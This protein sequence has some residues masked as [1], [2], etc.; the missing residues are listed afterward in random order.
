MFKNCLHNIYFPGMITQM[1]S[2]M[3]L[4]FYCVC[5]NFSSHFSY[6]MQWTISNVLLQKIW[7]YLIQVQ[8]CM[9]TNTHAMKMGNLHC[10]CKP[11]HEKIMQ[12][13]LVLAEAEINIKENYVNIELLFLLIS[14]QYSYQFIYSYCW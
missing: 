14:K 13:N 3:H 9:S 4:I 11:P 6:Q 5:C 7:L 1:F 12:S 2:L 8:T 10:L